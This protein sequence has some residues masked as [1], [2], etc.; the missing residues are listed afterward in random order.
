MKNRKL[1]ISTSAFIVLLIS[2][3][4]FSCT[5]S[6]TLKKKADK[7]LV[8]VCI[9]YGCNDPKKTAN[10][11]D[12]FAWT[13][14][15]A[16]VNGQLISIQGSFPDKSA[17]QIALVWNGNPSE[18]T[19]TLDEDASLGPNWGYA[20]YFLTL[21]QSQGYL[22]IDGG[23]GTATITNY[24]EE[25]RR[26][27]GTFSFK[28]KYFTGTDYENSYKEF[29]GSFK[30]IPIIDL[31]NPQF[32]CEA[33]GGDNSG[34]S[35]TGETSTITF[36]NMAFTPIEI[37]FN[38]QTKEAPAGGS[39]VFAGDPG[40]SIT[41]SAATSGKTTS[42]TQVGEKL[43]WTIT[44]SFPAANKN[45]DYTLN[46]GA[47]LFFLKIQNNSSL[48]LNKL[49]VNYGLTAQTLDNIAIPNDRVVYSLGYYKAYSNSNVRA[50]SG[51]TYWYWNNF[52]LPYTQNQSITL[53][54]N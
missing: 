27:S 23:T 51:N 43:N 41:G 4:H 40:K 1:L 26:I 29:S 53:S 32:P 20:S 44:T 47:D 22:T 52:T 6:T 48:S 54:A 11:E 5:K 12:A 39:T 15:D 2:V 35:G 14:Y 17:V 19:F 24:D 21:G 36:K 25:N 3:A 46:A 10:C 34:G 37:S 7:G 16:D 9:D 42:G 49:Y 45:L 28:G 8:Q 38:G 18:Q 13:Q 33:G 30:D 50:E 31:S